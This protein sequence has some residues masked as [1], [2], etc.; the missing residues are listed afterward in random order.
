[1]CFRLMR[2]PKFFDVFE[3]EARRVDFLNGI[4]QIIFR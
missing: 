1:M 3:Q 4:W 2:E